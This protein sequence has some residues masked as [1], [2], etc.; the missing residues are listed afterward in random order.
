M[1][2]NLPET[3]KFSHPN[4]FKEQK[5]TYQNLTISEDQTLIYR[6]NFPNQLINIEPQQI[7]QRR[8]PTDEDVFL[9]NQKMFLN[10]I[11]KF[12]ILYENQNECQLFLTSLRETQPQKTFN[13][14]NKTNNVNSHNKIISSHPNKDRIPSKIKWNTYLN[15]Q[16][17][18]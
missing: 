4:C 3:T 2:D 9:G 14:L 17:L 11:P 15:L 13:N 10:W 7:P 12:E 1:N 8:L 5:R 16:V 18:H 6:K